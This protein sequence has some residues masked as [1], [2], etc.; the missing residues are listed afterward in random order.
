MVRRASEGRATRAEQLSAA[1]KYA[2]LSRRSRRLPRR[3]SRRV[4]ACRVSRRTGGGGVASRRLSSSDFRAE[5][6]LRVRDSEGRARSATAR[7]RVE[8]RSQSLNLLT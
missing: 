4:A 1:A 8:T 6:L 3:R 5:L 7:R 2:V